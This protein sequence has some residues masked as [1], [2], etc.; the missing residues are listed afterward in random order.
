VIKLELG[1]ISEVGEA[2][3]TGLQY[4]AE[5]VLSVWHDYL[6]LLARLPRDPTFLDLPDCGQTYACYYGS[7]PVDKV[8]AFSIPH[9]S[10]WLF[11][12]TTR[13]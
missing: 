9:I 7:P 13:A 12:Q 1:G 4:V 10:S 6:D 5:H 3:S 8:P 2:E 11:T